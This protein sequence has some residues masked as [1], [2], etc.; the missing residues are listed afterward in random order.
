MGEHHPLIGT[1]ALIAAEADVASKRH[2]WLLVAR[3]AVPGVRT[4][5]ELRGRGTSIWTVRG[6]PDVREWG[7]V[8]DD[9]CATLICD[10]SVSVNWWGFLA[11]LATATAIAL[12]AR[13]W[14][15]DVSEP[16]GG[17]RPV[18]WFLVVVLVP[19]VGLLLF[20]IAAAKQIRAVRRSPESAK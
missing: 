6:V 11:V 17:H 3:G 13:M 16:W 19:P 1:I 8:V 2:P 12:V 14:S 18:V 9:K 4:S 5:P 10:V 7:Q 20:C 15:G